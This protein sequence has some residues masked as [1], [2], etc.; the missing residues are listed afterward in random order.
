MCLA[1]PGKLVEKISEEKGLVDLGGVTKEIALN[2]IPEVKIGEWI[3]IHTG[4]GLEIIS[5]EDALETIDLLQQAYG[6][7]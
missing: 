1:I 4:F 7:T 2:F 6:L 5:E 3:L